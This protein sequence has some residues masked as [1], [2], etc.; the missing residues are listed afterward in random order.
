MDV[1]GVIVAHA[2]EAVESLFVRTMPKNA[3]VKCSR[4]PRH[5]ARG[6]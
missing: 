2:G 5:A 4:L 3:P 6:R 1:K